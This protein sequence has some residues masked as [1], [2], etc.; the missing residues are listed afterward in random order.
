[1]TARMGEI[2][3]RLALNYWP[4]DAPRSCCFE[5]AM[6]RRF[7]LAGQFHRGSFA[8]NPAAKRRNRRLIR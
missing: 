4:G 2:M 7:A 5:K 3:R 1:L 8:D 6:T